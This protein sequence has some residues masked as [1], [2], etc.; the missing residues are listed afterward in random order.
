MTVTTGKKRPVRKKAVQIPLP[1]GAAQAVIDGKKFI[2]FPHDSFDAWCDDMVLSAMAEERMKNWDG[3]SVA[4][5]EVF[6]RQDAKRKG[7]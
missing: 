2:M 1:E 5:E 7:K 4:M 6:A 3:Q